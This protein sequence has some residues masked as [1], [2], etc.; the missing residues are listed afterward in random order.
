MRGES[1]WGTL[2]R[3]R[4]EEGKMRGESEEGRK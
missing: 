1:E 4:R 3:G 2:R